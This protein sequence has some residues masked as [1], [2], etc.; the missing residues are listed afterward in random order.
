MSHRLGRKSISSFQLSAI[1]IAMA[2]VACCHFSGCNIQS[3]GGTP[4]D[5]R[6]LGSVT[7]QI[8]QQQEQNADAAKFVVYNHEFELNVPLQN[9]TQMT[10]QEK[11]RFRATE[12]VRGFRLSPYGEDHVYQIADAILK[13]QEYQEPSIDAQWTPWDVIVERS[14]SSKLWDTRYRYPVHFNAELDEAR[15]QTVVALLSRLGVVNANEIVF[16]APAF[17]EGVSAEEAAGAWQSSIGNGN[18]RN[19]GQQF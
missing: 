4:I 7:D 14:E 13:H 9:E 11:F 8:N 17:S 3:P 5:T 19:Q 1:A 15:R 12:R 16:V 18:N 6:M 2:I 10:R